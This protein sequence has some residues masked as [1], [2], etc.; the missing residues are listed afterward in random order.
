M[1]FKTVLAAAVLSMVAGSGCVVAE[2]QCGFGFSDCG[3]Y[4]ADLS[5]DPRDCGRCGAT[6]A[7]GDYCDR[8]LCIVNSC[9][10]D[11]T[12]CGRDTDCCS[13]YCASDGVCGCIPRGFAG[14]TNS[15]DC[16]TNFCDRDGTCR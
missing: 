9:Y 4:C 5:S 16:C 6:C 11:G 7:A 3:D 2:P 13:N 1:N 15:V 8:G 10:S 14:C 12:A